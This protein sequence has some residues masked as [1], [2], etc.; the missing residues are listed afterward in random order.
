VVV[1]TL[2]PTARG[3]DQ[4]SFDSNRTFA[5]WDEILGDAVIA[6][7]VLDRYV[8]YVHVLNLNG[9]SYRTRSRKRALAP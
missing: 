6:G 3:V 4:P 9:E 8:H 7:A 1:L 2:V 5:D